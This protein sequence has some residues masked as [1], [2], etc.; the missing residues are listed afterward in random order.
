MPPINCT[1]CGSGF[2]VSVHRRR[3][4][5]DVGAIVAT[6]RRIF[7]SRSVLVADFVL[8]HDERGNAVAMIHLRR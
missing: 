8:T 5:G 4:R 1:A 3:R 7:L 6:R 2:D